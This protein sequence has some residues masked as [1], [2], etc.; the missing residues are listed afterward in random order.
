MGLADDLMDALSGEKKALSVRRG[1]DSRFLTDFIRTGIA[2]LDYVL[3]G[4]FARGRAVELFGNYSSGK[5]YILYL[6]LAA[7]Q[8]EGGVSALFETE[9]AFDPDFYRRCGGDPE[10]LLMPASDHVEGVLDG[11]VTICKHAQKLSDEEGKI[12]I[13]WDGIANT[14]TKHLLDTGMDKVD[15]SKSIRMSQ[16][17]ALIRDSIEKTRVCLI[18]TNQVREKINSMD[19]ETHT[20]GGKAYPYLASQRIELRFDGG[21]KTSL[22]C[23]EQDGEPIGRWL[24]AYVRK[25]KCG[26]PLQGVSLPFY[27]FEGEKH[28]VYGY[29]TRLGVDPCEALFEFYTKSRFHIVHKLDVKERAVLSPSPGWY[30]LHPKIDPEEK[31]FR[32]RDWPSILESM[33]ILWELPYMPEVVER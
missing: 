19:S 9:G 12:C 5:T 23:S 26:V 25:N 32:A 21:S 22:I 13:G 15:M 3:G 10:T 33:P 29:A 1:T 31:K 30:S 4:G 16:G 20:P 27:N 28:P 11:I 14:G 2:P 8:R 18:A 17:C 6:A 24:V 7:N